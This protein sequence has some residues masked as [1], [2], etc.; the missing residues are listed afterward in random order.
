ME[1]AGGGLAARPPQQ[2]PEPCD[3]YAEPGKRGGTPQ[4]GRKQRRVHMDQARKFSGHVQM[5]NQAH[6]SGKQARPH[7]SENAG[8]EDGRQQKQVERLTTE[9]R[10]EQ[11]PQDEGDGDQRQ[12]YG[13]DGRI[14]SQH[15]PD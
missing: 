9:R 2:L 8:D 4:L 11:R 13:V 15:G 1:F 12:R 6:G 14:R 7:P 3:R 10:S 5:E